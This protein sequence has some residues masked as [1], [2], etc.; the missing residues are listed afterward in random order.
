MKKKSSGTLCGRLNARGFKQIKAQC[1]NSTTISSPV[2]NSATIRIVLVLMVMA[3]MIAHIV[4]VKG[5]FLHGEFKDRGKVH[6]AIPHGFEKHFPAN[7]VILLLKCLYG[8]KQA[9]RAFW[10]QLL[11]AAKKM[12]LTRSSG[13]PCLYYKWKD[14]RL[15][16]MLSWIDN[17]AIVGYKKYMLDL[18]QDLM[19]QFDCDNCGKMDKYVGYTIKKL[20]SRD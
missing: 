10:R 13:D 16:M 4:D 2:P 14:G 3:S 1:Y 11:Q 5:A 19:K 9:A 8:L 15:V 17:N 6:M 12:G 20:E 18:K 7:S